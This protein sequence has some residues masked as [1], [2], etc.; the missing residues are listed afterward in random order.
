MK[1]TTWA[2][3]GLA[4][5]NRYLDPDVCLERIQSRGL[6]GIR[7][8]L[9][10]VLLFRPKYWVIENVQ[11]SA[12]WITSILDITHQIKESGQPAVYKTKAIHPS[13]KDKC[14]ESFKKTKALAKMCT[15]IY[16]RPIVLHAGTGSGGRYFFGHFPPFSFHNSWIKN[17]TEKTGRTLTKRPIKKLGNPAT[18]SKIDK[19][20]SE[21]FAKAFLRGIAKQHT[22][23][24]P[25]ISTF[26]KRQQRRIRRLTPY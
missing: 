23:S 26:T 20:I 19:Q 22:S 24:Q 17:K 18:R 12:P 8:V 11:R 1:G 10:A 21:A 6:K 25:C 9:R 2:C 14:H 3:H 15:K 5:V 16:G 7:T 13:K 4:G